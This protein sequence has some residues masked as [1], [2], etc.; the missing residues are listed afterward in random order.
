[1]VDMTRAWRMLDNEISMTPMPE[2]YNNFYVKVDFVTVF[3]L[4]CFSF[5][6]FCF[7]WGIVTLVLKL[8]GHLWLKTKP[9]T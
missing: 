9:G 8:L 3:S 1:M 5:F 7:I 6:F 2:K 4:F